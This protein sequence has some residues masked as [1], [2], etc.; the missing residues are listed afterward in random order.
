MAGTGSDALEDFPALGQQREAPF[1][2]APERAEQHIPGARVD[3]QLSHPCRFSYRGKDAVT[4]A[5]VAGI[6]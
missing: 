6:G 2:L 1:P 5:D 4:C 3:V